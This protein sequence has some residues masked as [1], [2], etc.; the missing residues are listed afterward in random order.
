M[1]FPRRIPYVDGRMEVVQLLMAQARSEFYHGRRGRAWETMYKAR[2]A[3]TELLSTLRGPWENCPDP[4]IACRKCGLACQDLQEEYME[5][6]AYTTAGWARLLRGVAALEKQYGVSIAW[7]EKFGTL[8]LNLQMP[9]DLT[10]PPLSEDDEADLRVLCAAI[11]AASIST[12]QMCG[13]RGEVQQHRM[14]DARWVMNLCKECAQRR[15]R[16]VVQCHKESG[17]PRS[18]YLAVILHDMCDSHRQDMQNLLPILAEE[19]SQAA[20]LGEI[21][22]KIPMPSFDGVAYK[23]VTS[24]LVDTET[25][26][27]LLQEYVAWLEGVG[28]AI[29]AVPCGKAEK[30]GRLKCESVTFQNMKC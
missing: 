28:N 10:K 5:W 13:V 9:T 23:N 12:C 14:P 15:M 3:L 27:R 11:E 19:E 2:A 18:P 7:K 8:R 20:A 29:R 4:R 25:C 17:H 30:T 21:L 26:K 1:T 16:F 22:A 24:R 6:R